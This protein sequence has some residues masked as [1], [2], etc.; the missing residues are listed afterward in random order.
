MQ[1]AIDPVHVIRQRVDV[2]GAELETF[3]GGAGAPRRPVICAAHPAGAFGADT[4]ALLAQAARAEVVCI[5]PRGLGGSTPCDAVSLEQMVDDIE[6]ARTQ[7]GL[8]PW[9]FWGMSGGGWLAQ[10]YAHRHRAGLAGIV[11]E[12]A[13]LCFRERLGDRSCALS[14]FFPAWRSALD[15]RGLI[16]EDSHAQPSSADDTEWIAVEGVGRVL[17]RR[18]GPALLVAPMPLEDEMTRALPTLWKFDA[19]PWVGSLHIP[20]LVICG[21]ADPVVPVHRVRAVHEALAGSTFVAVDGAA[22]V[23]TGERRSEVAEAFAQFARG[24]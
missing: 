3:R 12:S 1:P 21:T 16:A 8:G 13:C 24:L 18:G 23:P 19:R 17:R 6:R 5:N 15:A 4:L 9:L 14:P 22:H 7:L 2:G 11:V 10:L 20:A